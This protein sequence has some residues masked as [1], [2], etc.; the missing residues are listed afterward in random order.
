MLIAAHIL[1]LVG[2]ARNEQPHFIINQSRFLFFYYTGKHKPGYLN[3]REGS[4]PDYLDFLL[5]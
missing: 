1:K 4:R 3:L 2:F 5:Q